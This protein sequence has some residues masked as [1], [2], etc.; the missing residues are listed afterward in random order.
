[1]FAFS[2]KSACGPE[3]F[4]AVVFD[5]GGD[6]VVFNMGFPSTNKAVVFDAPGDLYGG[7][8]HIKGVFVMLLLTFQVNPGIRRRACVAFYLSDFAHPDISRK[9]R[10][11]ICD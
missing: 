2:A 10:L 8:Q 11:L 7:F 6:L 4:S 3:C 9:T 1:M 5:Q